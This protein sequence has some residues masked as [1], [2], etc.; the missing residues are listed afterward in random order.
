VSAG[1]SD[2][3]GV[4][5]VQLLLDGAPLG[6]E[7]TTAPYGAAWDTTSVADGPYTLTAT[8]RDAAGNTSTSAAVNVTVANTTG[9]PTAGATRFENT[10]PTIV[11]TDGTPAAGRP[12]KW[13]HGSRSRGWSGATSAFNRSQGARATFTFTGTGVRWIGFR[14]H[15]AGIARVS[16]D[17]APFTEIDLF[18]APDASDRLNGEKAQAVVYAATELPHGAHTLVVESTGRKRGGDACDAALDPANCASDWAV[19]VDAFD[20]LPSVAPP[21]AGARLEET[22]ATM[23][24]G[25]DGTA[26]AAGDPSQAWSG[27]SAVANAA[28]GARA[29][30]TF[31]GTS[32]R[33]IG[34]R[35]PGHGIARVY[36]DGS[37]HADI[38]TYSPLPVQA[39]AHEIAGLAPAR[40]TLVIEAT[41]LRNAASS[42]AVVV[43]DGVDVHTRFENQDPAVAYTGAWNLEDFQK[44]W[45]GTHGTTG[46]GTAALGRTAGDQAVFRFQGTEA[47]WIGY[48][49]PL[50]GLA[51]VYVDDALVGRV[52]LYAPVEQV[53]A[54]VF[55][56]GSLPDGPHTLRIL[57]TGEKNPAAG[58]AIVIV[59]AFDVSAPA[60]AAQVTRVQEN[61]PA[62]TYTNPADWTR[63]SRFPFDSGEFSMGSHASTGTAT[64]GTKATY[65]FRGTSVRVLGRRGFST[66]VARISLDGVLVATV[67]TQVPVASQEEFQAVLYAANG[68]AAGVDHTLEVELSGRN[69]EPAGAPVPNAVWLDAFD[70]Y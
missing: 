13:W 11:Y 42:G 54:E 27:G 48:R 7:D 10:E 4:A 25:T 1:A 50:A 32:V 29:T 44:A 12:D 35:G 63:G 15:W 3:V 21:V 65:R 2:D 36:L 64:A 46:S 9:V 18:S 6:P 67:D 34:F 43:V 52:D 70:I 19:V 60:A 26:W 69:G 57:V 56:T 53:Q 62:V 31:T 30:F 8:A 28:A 39:A 16:L 47:R 68:L 40:H 41:G 58:A 37:A 51:D 45:S 22:S 49:G 66:G 24:A 14:A 59:D 17:G 33:W 5:G 61:D 20:V 55:A 38:D 23:T